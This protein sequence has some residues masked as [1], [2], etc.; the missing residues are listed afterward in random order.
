ML[1]NAQEWAEQEFGNVKLGDKRLDKRALE[2]AARLARRP[3]DS[4]PQ[5]MGSWAAQK[6]TYRLLDNDAVSY[7]ALS[8]PHWQKTRQSCDEQDST[9]LLV[10]DITELDYS[11]HKATDG[12]GPIGDHRGRG[13]LVHNT[14]ALQANTGNVMG[15][16]YQQVWERPS[17]NR[18]RTETKA[19]RQQRADKQ[20]ARWVQAIR[21]IGKPTTNAR[22]VH[23]GDRESDIF[24]LFQMCADTGVDF[25]VRIL[26]NRRVGN[27]SEA[28][29]RYLVSDLRQLAP[30]GYRVLAIPAQRG[31]PKREARLSI[32]WQPVT[33]RSPR[34]RPGEETRLNL[35]AVRVW[36]PH[37]P[38]ATEPIEWLLLTSVPVETFTDALERI[39]WYTYRWVVEEYHKCLKTG[40]GMEKRRLQS[41]ERL[42]RLLAFL[43]ILAV[44]LLQLRDMARTKP[45]QKVLTVVQPLLVQIVA[46]RTN[47]D[48]NT[49]TLHQFWHAVAQIGGFPQRKSDGEP[50]WERLWHGWLRLLDW[51]EGVSFANNLPPIQD[52]GNC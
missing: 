30:M 11:S 23:V 43:S 8:R 21:E 15:L 13:M 36:E 41:A 37:P 47:S 5:Q 14:L 4:L 29:P 33:I 22:W 2:I 10:Q 50:G 49:M 1:P 7:E 46:A 27:W 12:L 26:Q 3:S 40:C 18:K 48:P 44:R 38:K 24:D 19:Q 51:A 20:S 52:V 16:A 31:K 32:S 45:Q 42:H 17:I 25:C 6:A 35:W 39:D 34:N 28:T 9:F